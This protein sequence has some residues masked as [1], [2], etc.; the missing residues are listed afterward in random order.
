MVRCEK[1]N[2]E[3]SDVELRK[4]D[5]LLCDTCYS[6]N[7]IDGMRELANESFGGV[8]LQNGELDAEREEDTLLTMMLMMAIVKSTCRMSKM[9]WKRKDG[10]P[11]KTL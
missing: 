4:S 1:C 3:K 10:H 9:R 6:K 8:L 2:D 5:E 7:L 11:G